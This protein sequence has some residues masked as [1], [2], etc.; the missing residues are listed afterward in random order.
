MKLIVGT[1]NFNKNF[2][3]SK[4]NINNKFKRKLI[5]KVGSLR[6]SVIDTSPEYSNAEHLIGKNFSKDLKII[7]KISKLKKKPRNLVSFILNQTNK[8]LK[9]LKQKSIHGILLHNSRD[10]LENKKEFIKLIAL[11]KI[12]K[13]AKKIGISIYE[14]EELFRIQKFWLPDFI[15]V[16]YNIFNREIENKRFIKLIEKHKIEIHVRSIFLKGLL[17]KK[18]LKVK[19]LYRLKK[20]FLKWFEWCKNNNIKPYEACYLFA[21]KNKNINKI[22]VSFD[23][24]QQLEEILKIRT[25][26]LRFPDLRPRNKD[27]LNPSTW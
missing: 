12:R 6:E 24:M 17:S 14:I 5:R 15:Q 16:P 18:E 19:K 13:Y 4:K 2:I 8:S 7:T 9:K 23:N 26:K 11:L 21:H 3:L 27:I 25:R 10:F 1:G 22:V 20:S